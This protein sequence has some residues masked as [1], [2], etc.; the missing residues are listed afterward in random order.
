MQSSQNKFI[1]YGIL[2][3][4]FGGVS[5][6]LKRF[7][8]YLGNCG[9]NF[10]FVHSNNPNQKHAF[11]KL[12]CS[13][14]NLEKNI[15][16]LHGFQTGKKLLFLLF[17]MFFCRKNVV[18]TIHNDRFLLDYNSLK[19][20]K[21]IIAKVFYSNIS[22]IISVNPDSKY[23][24]ITANKISVIPAFIPPAPDETDIK[25]L[26][27]IFH[28]IRKKHKFLI[29]ANASTI[30]FYNNQDL[31]GIDLSIQ[32]MKRLVNRGY[33]Q[34]GFIY[35]IPDTGDY[36]YYDK[37]KRQVE[38]NNLPECFH[39]YTQPVA[40]PAVINM[41]D[42]FIRQTNTD[43]D[44]LSIREAL[45][46]Q[47]PAIASDVCKRPKGTILFKNRNIDDLY[48]NTKYV[49]DN[50]EGCKKQIYNIEFEDNAEKILEV[51]SKVLKDTKDENP[52]L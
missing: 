47:K 33:K 15:I 45:T 30:S 12:F 23:S 52:N 20:I 51:Y 34:I 1:I 4:P 36:D 50:Y 19:N 31:Y 39:F 48:N 5:I 2:P 26:P 29:T 7:K 40:Y 22:H 8:N 35:V 49:I 17:L 21:K 10:V 32:L 25:Q 46:L 27:E 9:T 43:G 42:L 38:N 24:F 44:A 16:H 18:V 11:M 14:L 28:Q 37:M 6:H 13:Q 41:C 3:P